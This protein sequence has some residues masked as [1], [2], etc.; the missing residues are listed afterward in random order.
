MSP[1]LCSSDSSPQSDCIHPQS[2]WPL[3]LRCNDCWNGSFL[4]I[5]TGWTLWWDHSSNDNDCCRGSLSQL[6]TSATSGAKCLFCCRCGTVCLS[7]CLSEQRR[8]WLI[9]KTPWQQQRVQLWMLSFLC[10]SIHEGN[11][12]RT[13][14]V[15]GPNIDVD[16]PCLV[17]SSNSTY[18]GAGSLPLVWWFARRQMEGTHGD[19][20]PPSIISL[21]LSHPSHID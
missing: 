18:C 20:G 6:M 11:Q 2:H 15:T 14:L 16:P 7:V 21:V 19:G 1:D 3:W 8:S 12:T 13:T 9:L 5:D 10:S 4:L 17:P